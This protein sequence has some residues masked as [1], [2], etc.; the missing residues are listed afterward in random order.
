MAK[1]NQLDNILQ[2]ISALD[3]AMANTGLVEKDV[4]DDDEE[5]DDEK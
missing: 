5:K 2:C 3:L 4:F 1:N